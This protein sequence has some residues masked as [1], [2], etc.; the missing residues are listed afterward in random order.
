MFESRF[1]YI[2]ELKKMGADITVSGEEAVFAG[3]SLH[4]ADVYARDL[5]GGAALVLAALA[6]EGGR[7][8]VR[9]ADVIDRGYENFTGI[10][11]SLGADI[12]FACECAEDTT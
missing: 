11:R 2:E 10:L 4:A 12:E 7:T 5:R 9:N 3:G 6:A 8:L 1:R